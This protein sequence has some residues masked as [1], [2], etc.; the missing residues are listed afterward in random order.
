MKFF[1]CLLAANFSNT[2]LTFLRITSAF[3]FMPHGAQKLFG[4][5]G[6]SGL[7][8]TAAQMSSLGIE[9]AILSKIGLDPATVMAL[10]SGGAEFFGG[11]FLLFGFLTRF[12]G[13][14]LAFNM[15]IA[16]LIVHISHGFFATSGGYEY[17]LTLLII[18]VTFL[19][20]GGGRCSLDRAMAGSCK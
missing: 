14:V 19:I 7:Q 15:A 3:I 6:G 1:P 18:G 9:P 4:W 20:A 8:A 10:L 17:A 13:F 2:G 5:F 12:A 11:L 16:I